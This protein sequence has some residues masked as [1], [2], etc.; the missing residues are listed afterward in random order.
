MTSDESGR[1]S[2]KVRLTSYVGHLLF[3][4]ISPLTPVIEPLEKKCIWNVFI[5]I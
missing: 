4:T 5:G 1:S 2:D 3:S